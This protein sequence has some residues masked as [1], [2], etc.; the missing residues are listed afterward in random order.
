MIR[1]EI[2]DDVYQISI[3]G[4]IVFTI[5]LDKQLDQVVINTGKEVYAG[6]VDLIAFDPNPN[7]IK[8]EDK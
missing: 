8:I 7:M 2:K 4:K 5:H 1:H 3:D 6:P